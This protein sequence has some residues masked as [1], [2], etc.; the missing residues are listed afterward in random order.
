LLLHG[1]QDTD[2][3]YEQSALMAAAVGKVGVAHELITIPGGGHG[4]DAEPDALGEGAVER[5]V[6]FLKRHV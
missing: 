2:V 1:G 6:E 5:V 3:P 4:F